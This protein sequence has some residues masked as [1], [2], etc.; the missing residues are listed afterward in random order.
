MNKPIRTKVFGVSQKNDDDRSRQQLIRRFVKQGEILL[1][2]REPTNPNDKNAISVSVA[3][4]EYVEQDTKIGYISRELAA[5]LAPIMDSGGKIVCI[6]LNRTGGREGKSFGVNIELTVYTTEEVAEYYKNN[7]KVDWRSQIAQ[8]IPPP[9]PKIIKQEPR[10]TKRK[11]FWP[12]IVGLTVLCLIS[13]GISEGLQSFGIRLDPLQTLVII[14]VSI[15]LVILF[16][17]IF[18]N[19]LKK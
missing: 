13:G 5:D 18:V 3:P 4:I 10:K 16:Y 12:V 17:K 6:V 15:G 7:P 19:R 1:L 11:L 8:S 14:A 9:L 2:D